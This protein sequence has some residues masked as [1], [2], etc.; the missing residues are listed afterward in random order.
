[1]L[2]SSSWTSISETLE[3]SVM[4]VEAP[5]TDVI[6]LDLGWKRGRYGSTRAELDYHN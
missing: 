4:A 2:T 1:M 5:P 6:E 3:T